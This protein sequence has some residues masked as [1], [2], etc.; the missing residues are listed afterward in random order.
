MFWISLYKIVYFMVCMGGYS[1]LQYLVYKCMHACMHQLLL[2]ISSTAD[3]YIQGVLNQSARSSYNSFGSLAADFPACLRMLEGIP[4]IGNFTG[5][6][7]RVSQ[8]KHIS[9]VNSAF[10]AAEGNGKWCMHILVLHCRIS[11]PFTFIIRVYYL[12]TAST[13]RIPV[14]YAGSRICT[15]HLAIE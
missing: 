13:N 7:S 5:H 15:T 2:H 12:Y 10:S 8:F 4:L 9:L 11:L 1:V 3:Y 6:F 14:S